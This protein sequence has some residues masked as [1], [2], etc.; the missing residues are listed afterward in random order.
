MIRRQ[1]VDPNRKFWA[2]DG[3]REWSYFCYAKDAN[4][5]EARLERKFSKVL[6]IESYDF[7]EWKLRAKTATDKANADYQKGK[8][9]ISFNQKI[10]AE[11]KWHLFDLFYGKCAYCESKPEAVYAGDVEHYRPKAKVVEDPGH[12]GYF[13]LAYEIS[14]LLPSCASCNQFFGKMNH[15][16]VSGQHARDE[17]SV[18]TE[19]PLLLNPYHPTMEPLKHLRFTDTGK[20]V[21]HED[22]PYGAA[23][24]E[25]YYLNRPGL[26]E[27]RL[28]AI[29]EVRQDWSTFIL[30]LAGQGPI[31]VSKILRQE[32][33]LGQRA[34]CAAQLCELE[35]I[36][37]KGG[38]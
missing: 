4:E 25:Y 37:L 14:N 17:Q 10:W 6:K 18:P 20:A 23:S 30:R 3:K 31:E 35:R 19:D 26:G 24:I 21:P 28:T 32:L 1:W 2:T 9:P 8:R 27:P 33:T 13:W 36:T 12:P 7:S 22:S 5:L 38:I 11:L 16:P 29:Q 34:Y 15:F